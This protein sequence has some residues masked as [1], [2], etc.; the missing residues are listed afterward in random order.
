MGL[1]TPNRTVGAFIGSCLLR[2][3]FPIKDNARPNL[4]EGTQDWERECWHWVVQ[5]QGRA[6]DRAHDYI[7]QMPVEEYRCPN[8]AVV[9]ARVAVLERNSVAVDQF[10]DGDVT[11]TVQFSK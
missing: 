11:Y 1:R 3:F 6:L 5:N 7:S 4:R 8:G 9:S 10:V 2:E